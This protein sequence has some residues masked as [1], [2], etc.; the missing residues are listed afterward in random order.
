MLQSEAAQLALLTGIA[1]G[2]AHLHGQQPA[3]ILH[4]DLKTANVLVWP[5]AASTRFVAKISDFGLATGSHDSTMRTAHAKTGAA[6]LAYKAPEAFDDEFSAASEVYAFAI[7]AW[8]VLTAK[9]PWQGYSEARL[10][11][12]IIKEERPPLPQH[13]DFQLVESCWAQEA[14][15]RPTFAA[16][17]QG[18]QA[19]VATAVAV[20]AKAR[21]EPEGKPEGWTGAVDPLVTSRVELQPGAEYDRVTSAFMASLGEP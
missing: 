4:H 5:D 11:K 20:S 10:T 3:P 16:L 12:A 9:V 21:E 14:K 17:A 2:M 13:G 7:V 15:D 1:L 19:A 8:E 6:T 18:L